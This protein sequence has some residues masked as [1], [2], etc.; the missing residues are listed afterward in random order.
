M[1]RACIYQHKEILLQLTSTTNKK[2]SPL[3]FLCH[4]PN[5][6]IRLPYFIPQ[7]SYYL[8]NSTLEE[9]L[10]T[11]LLLSQSDHDN[12]LETLELTEYNPT[13]SQSST[14]ARNGNYHIYLKKPGDFIDAR[15]TCCGGRHIQINEEHISLETGQIKNWKKPVVKDIE[16]L[17]A[18]G[19]DD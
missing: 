6:S 14:C 16:K 12:H 2:P 5:L 9:E 13:P 17:L 1:E 18:Q 15:C 10:E 4:Y 8:E 7:Q 19:D 3:G 11:W